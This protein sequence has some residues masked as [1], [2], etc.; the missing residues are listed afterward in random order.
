MLNS[1]FGET[2]EQFLARSR[3]NVCLSGGECNDPTGRFE[4]YNPVS[5]FTA[6]TVPY[7]CCVNCWGNWFGSGEVLE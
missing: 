1:N 4:H 3:T 6:Q 2:P 5:P 7:T